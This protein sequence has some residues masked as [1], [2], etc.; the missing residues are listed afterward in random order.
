MC[1]SFGEGHVCKRLLVYGVVPY[2]A[3]EASVAPHAGGG[4]VPCWCARDDI[5]PG[6]WRMAETVQER[7]HT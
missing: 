6:A 2:E 7:K 3:T 4:G 1:V 5:A